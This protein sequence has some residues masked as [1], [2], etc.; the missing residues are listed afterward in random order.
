[1]NAGLS[2]S[3]LSAGYGGRMVLQR[4]DLPPTPP[5]TLVALVGPNA[6]GKS[7]LL[8]AIAGLLPAIGGIRLDGE[9]LA[10]QPPARRLRRIGYLPQA[11]PQA[12][13]LVAYEALLSAL[14]ATDPARPRPQ[15][16]AAIEQVLTAL[17]LR[18]LAFRR[19]GEL[20][21]GQRQMVGLAQVMVRRPRLLLLDEPTSALDLRWQLR[22][23]AGVR[24][25][26]EA[27]QAI[28]LFAIHDLNLALRFCDRIVVLREGRVLAA[29]EP[30]AVFDAELL[31]RAYGV[32]G[33]VERCSLGHH[34]VIVD[35]E[36]TEP[37][38]A[39][40]HPE[41]LKGAQT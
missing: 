2:I 21:G 26:A 5:G 14:S 29:G 39:S 12:S 30:A 35:R 28:A 22:V 20:S 27:D 13:A 6:A 32:Q 41:T 10:G 33:R 17:D 24:R 15:A 4:L 34:I 38:P 25:L 23:L 9:E 40:T 7:T 8:K 31:A 3:G 18:D 16:E 11:L 37:A 1:M 19:M 36:R